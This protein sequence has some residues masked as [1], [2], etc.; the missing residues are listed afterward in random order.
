MSSPGTRESIASW[1][2]SKQRQQ[3]VQQSGWKVSKNS[4]ED[5]TAQPWQWCATGHGSKQQ[6]KQLPQHIRCPSSSDQTLQE[7]HSHLAVVY[8]VPSAFV[9]TLGRQR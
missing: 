2:P 8:E 1:E 3:F 9:F 7:G 6:W 4:P 5:E